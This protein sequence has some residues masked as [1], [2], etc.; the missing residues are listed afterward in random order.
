MVLKPGREEAARAVFEK[1]ELEFAVVGTLT[2]TGRLVVHRGGGIAADIPVGPLVGEAPEYDRP[3]VAPP[4]AK[5]L[6]DD[7]DRLPVPPDEALLRLMACPD[8][9]SKRWIWEQY[10]S[11]VMADT[12]AGPGGDAAI[13]RVHGTT[14]A[15]AITSDCTPRYCVADP[16][17]GG[18]QA[19]AEAWRNLTAVGAL[20]LAVT[21]NLNFGNPERPPIMGQLVDCI[22]GMGEACR[23]LDVPVVSGNV[24]LYNE[25]DGEPILP[26]PTIGAVGVLED[27]VQRAGLALGDEGLT[28][29]LVGETRGH[30]GASLFLREIRGIEA[31]PPPP[32]DLAVERTA[33]D[34]VRTLIRDGLVA[35][36]HD[37][38]D[39]G[40]YVAV[41][42]MALAGGIG[43]DL[44]VPEGPS[45]AGWL[46]GEDQ[47][48][49]V[50]ATNDANAV[51]A[52]ADTAGVPASAIGR[53]GGSALTLNG[54][55]AISLRSLRHAHEHWL[56]A[57]MAGEGH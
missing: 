14:K 42:E 41:A 21:D 53:S 35:A 22:R 4:P 15:L 2:D 38:S 43:A 25:T 24:S 49:Y 30:L 32:V 54:Q 13:V 36:C 18:A 57:Y 40:L 50:V 26:T 8:L 31:G 7:A 47:A 20:P 48:R 52:R 45:P 39:G 6:P 23:A 12:V 1:W 10:D 44:A 11:T 29:V 56:A 27:V 33:G 51:L 19:V 16:A 5:P 37:V 3:W 17:T 34:L 55:S 46:F 28:L 9:A